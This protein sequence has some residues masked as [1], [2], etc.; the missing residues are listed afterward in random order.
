M[1][2]NIVMECMRQGCISGMQQKRWMWYSRSERNSI[3]TLIIQCSGCCCHPCERSRCQNRGHAS[4]Y[5][6]THFWF[7]KERVCNYMLFCKC[8]S[9][10]GISHCYVLS[11]FKKLFG[12]HGIPYR[13]QQA[14]ATN[15]Q[16]Q[17][18]YPLTQTSIHQ[19]VSEGVNKK[20]APILSSPRWGLLGGC[21]WQWGQTIR[22]LHPP[23]QG[24]SDSTPWFPCHC[25]TSI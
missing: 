4:K 7:L 1:C 2:C 10:N 15:L 22:S 23:C 25:F 11:L 8:A 9:L 20:A 24:E 14:E 16:G 3:L 18:I 21:S 19:A 5:C 13:P 12:N 6:W 17:R